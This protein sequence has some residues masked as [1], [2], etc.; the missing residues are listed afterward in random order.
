MAQGGIP[1][2]EWSG[3]N[4]VKELHATIRDFVKC[5]NRSAK[6]MVRLTCVIAVLTLVMVAA[7]LVQ[8]LVALR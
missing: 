2:G 3:S 6:W 1:L 7:V 4:A 8:I 5:S